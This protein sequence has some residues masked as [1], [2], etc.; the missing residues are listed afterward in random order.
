MCIRDRRL[1][2]IV[3]KGDHDTMF[4]E[5]PWDIY[6]KLEGMSWEERVDLPNYFFKK[7]KKID[8]LIECKERPF[9][10]WKSDIEG[11]IIPYYETYRPR[12]MALV[13]AHP[14]PEHVRSR[15]ESIVIAVISP[16]SPDETPYEQ[17]LVLRDLIGGL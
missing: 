16:F 10:E 4:R 17:E 6:E 7:M 2:I 12:K 3:Q 15:L 8:L 9:E 1:D 5:R 14:L 13:S 11:Q